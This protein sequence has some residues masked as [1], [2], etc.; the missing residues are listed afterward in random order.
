M[1]VA[2]RKCGLYRLLAVDPRDGKDGGDGNV[3]AV[4]EVVKA[5]RDH[6]PDCRTAPARGFKWARVGSGL[7]TRLSQSRS[8]WCL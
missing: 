3:R 1:Q 7:L 6:A 4:F 5:T 8:R 2:R